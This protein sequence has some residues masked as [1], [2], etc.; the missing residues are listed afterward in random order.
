MAL[1]GLHTI[2]SLLC[3]VHGDSGSESGTAWLTHN[4]ESLVCMVNCDISSV[5]GTIC[6]CRILSL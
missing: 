6:L 1:P 5:N 2:L 3:L 4:I